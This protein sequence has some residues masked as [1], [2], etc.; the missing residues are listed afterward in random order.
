MNPT[1]V[2]MAAPV[3]R[4]LVQ[5][6]QLVQVAMRVR[7]WDYGKDHNVTNP[8]HVLGTRV[9]DMASVS[10]THKAARV[11]VT[12]VCSFIPI[13][14]SVNL[15]PLCLRLSTSFLC[16]SVCQ[17]RC[18]ASVA[19]RQSVERGI[20]RPR[21]RNSLAPTGFTLRQCNQSALL[22]GPIRW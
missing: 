16:V 6:V 22:G 20:E 15:V 8:L 1:R 17:P 12:Q 14:Q 7:V 13:F 10:S 3:N 18:P 9:Q 4:R 21:V 2:R 5:V 11:T 19:Q